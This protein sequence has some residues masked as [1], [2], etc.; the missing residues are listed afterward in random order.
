MTVPKWIVWESR[1]AFINVV[2]R[3]AV[4]V[5]LGFI[6]F[7]NL[8]TIM[9]VNRE[10]RHHRGTTESL[11]KHND[12]NTTEHRDA[13]QG[14]HNNIMNLICDIIIKRPPASITDGQR[15]ACE[16]WGTQ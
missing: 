6:I 3:I 7:L 13:N 8:S 16:G 10:L 9:A 4:L 11:I 5:L 12:R 14:D 1:K 15:K 2:L